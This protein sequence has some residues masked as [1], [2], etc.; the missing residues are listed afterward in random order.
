MLTRANGG[1]LTVQ[2]MDRA[3]E[4]YHLWLFGQVLFTTPHGDT[5]DARW[6]AVAQEITDAQNP[7]QV[8]PRSWGSA[9]LAYTFRALSTTC[10]KAEGRPTLTGCPLLLQ[11]WCYERFPIGGPYVNAGESYGS[12]FYPDAGALASCGHVDSLVGPARKLCAAIHP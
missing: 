11:L 6:I 7:G 2:Q 8:T 12:D 5:I 3:L 1:A 10:F 4:A 9:V